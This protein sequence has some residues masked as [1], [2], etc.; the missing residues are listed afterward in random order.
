MLNFLIITRDLVPNVG[1]GGG[2][3]IKLLANTCND[4]KT[5]QWTVLHI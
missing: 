4:L 1:W 2:A 3:G 5:G